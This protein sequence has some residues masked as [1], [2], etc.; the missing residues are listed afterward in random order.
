MM[1]VYEERISYRKKGEI[2]AES[3][4]G[5][6]A[7]YD[8]VNKSGLIEE[9]PD[10]EGFFVIPLNRKNRPKGGVIRITLGTATSALVH[11]RE[12]FKPCILASA[13]GVIIAHNHPSGDPSPSTADIRI[14]RQIHEA[15]EIIGIDLLDHVIIGTNEG[16]PDNVPFYSFNDNVLL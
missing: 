1:N 8:Y 13:S 2:S 5:P 3:L 10:Q 14:T 6:E 15:S 4:E 12:V 7:V 16:S 9:H 11:P